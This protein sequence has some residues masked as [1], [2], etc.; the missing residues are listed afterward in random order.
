MWREEINSILTGLS[1]AVIVM[2]FDFAMNR[3]QILSFWYKLI[4]K[5]HKKNSHWFK[6]SI[7]KILGFCPIC[8]GLW[9]A[10]P[11][12]YVF[13]QH[14]VMEIQVFVFFIASSQFILISRYGSD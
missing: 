4:G 6:K 10:Y 13:A 14:F 7:A 12:Y 2:M 5:W 11:A 9:F 1:W 8:F 3:G